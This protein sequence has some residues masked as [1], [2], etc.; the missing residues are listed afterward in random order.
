MTT[1]KSNKVHPSKSIQSFSA[2]F[3]PEKGNPSIEGNINSSR[4]RIPKIYLVSMVA[5]LFIAAVL[6]A[7]IYIDSAEIYLFEEMRV[8]FDISYS[9]IFTIL[10][11]FKFEIA[12][13]L[14]RR[15][16]SVLQNDS[17]GLSDKYIS[18]F[19]ISKN[20]CSYSSS[21]ES[22]Q[23]LCDLFQGCGPTV[24]TTCDICDVMV[25]LQNTR[26][27]IISTTKTAINGLTIS[28]YGLLHQI[29]ALFE[30]EIDSDET[31][32]IVR[33]VI[34]SL[35]C[36]VI[37]ATIFFILRQSRAVNRK[38]F[39]FAI[40]LREKTRELED[41]K[42]VTEELLY[43]MIPKSIAH[44]LQNKEKISA[45]FFEA[46]TIFFSDIVGFTSISAR[47]TPMQV[48][49]LLNSLYSTFDIRIDTYDVYKVETIGDAYMVASGVPERNG[50]RHVEEIATMAIDL[51][52]AIKQVKVPHTNSDH[53]QIRIGCH[54]G[55]CVAGVVGLKM[56]RYC[57]FG[58]TVNTASRMEANSQPLKIH[59]SK[60]TRDRLIVTDRYTLEHRGLIEIKGKGPM[61]TYWLTGRKDMGVANDS[62]VCK[63]QPRKKK[64]KKPEN[65]V[66][67]E[68]STVSSAS[69]L[70]ESRSEHTITNGSGVL[71]KD[72]PIETK[73]DSNTEQPASVGNEATAMTKDGQLNESHQIEDSKIETNYKLP[74]MSEVQI[75]VTEASSD[76]SPDLTSDHGDAE[77]RH[78]S[79]PYDTNTE[80]SSKTQ[81]G[82]QIKE[83]SSDGTHPAADDKL[84]VSVKQLSPSKTNCQSTENPPLKTI[85]E[86]QASVEP[87]NYTN[88][89]MTEVQESNVQNEGMTDHQH[90]SVKND[91]MADKFEQSSKKDDLVNNQI[92]NLT[93]DDEQNQ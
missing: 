14:V 72:N 50:E 81:N 55:A 56:P 34:R 79:S 15:F 31:S 58:D 4:I 24:N 60:D 59:V 23:S 8:E 48:V 11:I 65:S 70:F 6:I 3:D 53:V 33:V 90:S 80:D 43:Q 77:F 66:S 28:K 1:M 83:T 32:D 35:L 76:G 61:D 13:S 88:K 2:Y 93:D 18:P 27:T 63:W 85:Y 69:T 29:G 9:Q 21:L 12:N 44:Q 40:Q 5:F 87:Y 39:Q 71:V 17:C 51:L 52:A 64:K 73:T 54:T 37:S 82:N 10:D 7:D 62:M 16:T 45:E 75:Q 22:V 49:E 67:A 26:K 30:S 74:P 41:K 78:S 86:D 84:S 20:K 38:F 68:H 91:D 19:L 47:C 25:S 46:V 36:I 57:L 89:T 42:K 92:S